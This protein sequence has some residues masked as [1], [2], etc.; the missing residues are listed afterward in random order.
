MEVDVTTRTKP[1]TPCGTSG[2]VEEDSVLRVPWCKRV[3]GRPS[4][5]KVR[6]KSLASVHAGI[7]ETGNILPPSKN[8]FYDSGRR[9]RGSVSTKRHLTSAGTSVTGRLQK[10]ITLRC[11]ALSSH[12]HTTNVRKTHLP[13]VAE[14]PSK[15]GTLPLLNLPSDAH[16]QG[17]TRE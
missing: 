2:S 13:T 1:C 8:F 15:R 12:K 5:H 10:E 7:V 3:L 16:N 9:Q 11:S 4:A 14:K 17:D 6:S